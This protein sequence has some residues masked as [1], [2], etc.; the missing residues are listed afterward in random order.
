MNS[1]EA[2]SQGPRTL[3]AALRV[4]FSHLSPRILAATVLTALAVRLALG[5]FGW[6]D[7]A[8]FAVLLAIWPLQE[9]LIHVFILHYRPVRFAGR[10]WD[11]A[12]PRKHREHHADPWR[13]DLLFIPTHV[14]SY[15][16]PLH[17][18][19]W[20]GVMPTPELA[21]SGLAAYFTL[22]LHYEWVHYLAHVP[23]TPPLER[24]RRLIKLHQRHHFKNEHYWYGVT[25]TSADYWLA[26]TAEPEHVETSPTARELLA[27]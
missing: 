2:R 13:L 15:G 6:I 9:W 20:F 8:P 22:A 21:C 3:A 12:V 27:S 1:T 24:Y 11:F 5:G 17:A 18:L 25:M 16:L 10:T 26:T 7:L 4:F 14:F 19:F 23:Y